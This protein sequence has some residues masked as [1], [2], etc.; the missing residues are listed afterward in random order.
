MMMMYDCW[1]QYWIKIK[2]ETSNTNVA[3]VILS[4][5]LHIDVAWRVE[6]TP[7]A[8]RKPVSNYQFAKQSGSHRKRE[9]PTFW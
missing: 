6:I 8:V 5:Q 4:A 7:V 3:V 2:C 9:K 1:L